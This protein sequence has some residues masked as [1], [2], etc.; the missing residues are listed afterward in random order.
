MRAVVSRPKAAFVFPIRRMKLSP[1][2]TLG[3]VLGELGQNVD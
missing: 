3:S 1:A 2:S